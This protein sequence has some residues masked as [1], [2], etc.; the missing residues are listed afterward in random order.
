MIKLNNFMGSEWIN[1]HIHNFNS[2]F[3]LSHGIRG[4]GPVITEGTIFQSPGLRDKCPNFPCLSQLEV[5]V[6]ILN[7]TLAEGFFRGGERREESMNIA[8]CKKRKEKRI[9][10]KLRKT[11]ESVHATNIICKSR[12]KEVAREL[13]CER[14][15][16][17][18]ARRAFGT[19]R[20]ARGKVEKGEWASI[21]QGT[22]SVDV[23]E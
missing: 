4:V 8:I 10:W 6:E 13:D 16:G 7:C 5:T 22:W 20:I 11:K 9:W 12:K 23:G 15:I 21:I 18:K 17:T 1:T 14:W 2:L 3:P 19:Q